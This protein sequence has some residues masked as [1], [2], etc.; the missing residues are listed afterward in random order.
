ML[1]A[2]S[3]SGY[4]PT[5]IVNYGGAFGEQLRQFVPHANLDVLAESTARPKNSYALF[6]TSASAAKMVHK[7]LK[8]HIGAQANLRG[9]SN[10]EVINL[11]DTHS[12]SGHILCCHHARIILVYWLPISRKLA[13][14]IV[15]PP[16]INLLEGDI[17]QT[18]DIRL[19]ARGGR[20]W[21]ASSM[22]EV[23]PLQG[24]RQVMPPFNPV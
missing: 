18:R 22:E 12:S 20:F 24:K 16:G 7:G 21:D 6:N 8:V 23:W 17:S 14:L 4:T 10:Y 2:L 13:D 3:G 9:L 19:V 1:F 15:Y 11:P 5:H